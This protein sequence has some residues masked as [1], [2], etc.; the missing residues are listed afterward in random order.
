MAY[1][2]DSDRSAHDDHHH[3][4]QFHGRRKHPAHQLPFVNRIKDQSSGERLSFWDV[5]ATGGYMGGVQTG[6]A[7]GL[8]FFKRMRQ[9]PAQFKCILRWIVLEMKGFEVPDY[10][11]GETIEQSRAKESLKG[12]IVGFMSVIE[13]WIETTC[14]RHTAK[15]YGEWIDGHTVEDLIDRANNG[16]AGIIRK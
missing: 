14:S 9:D 2:F 6:R 8:L 12:Q 3:D 5:P 4:L 7:M 15:T 16:L 10:I 13:E 11:P 1:T